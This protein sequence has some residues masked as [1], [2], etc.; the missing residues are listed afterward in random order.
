M[1]VAAHFAAAY[2]AARMG[3]GAT[4]LYS[5]EAALTALSWLVY[6]RAGKG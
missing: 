6:T 4:L 1:A 2:R 5:A 3:L